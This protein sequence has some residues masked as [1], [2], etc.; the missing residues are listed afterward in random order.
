M[1]PKPLPFTGQTTIL[2]AMIETGPRPNG[3]CAAPLHDHA[4]LPW[5]FHPRLSA[6]DGI[7]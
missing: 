7:L 5:R 3:P 6:A 2:P 1:H 4:L